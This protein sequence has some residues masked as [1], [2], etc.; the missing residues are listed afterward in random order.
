MVVGV[1][2]PFKSI[3]THVPAQISVEPAWR[4][5]C[6]AFGLDPIEPPTRG[7]AAPA[8]L[9][10]AVPLRMS[11][12]RVRFKMME[13][14]V[15]FVRAFATIKPTPRTKF[16]A[17]E[18]VPVKGVLRLYVKFPPRIVTNHL[19]AEGTE[20]AATPHTPTTADDD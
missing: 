3:P 11:S 1:A 7:H 13:A 15:K 16:V 4:A 20:K 5:I 18:E 6:V 14:A 12:T 17:V 10:T 9:P 2:A 19:A 8:G